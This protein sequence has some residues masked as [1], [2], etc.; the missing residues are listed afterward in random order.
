MYIHF[1]YPGYFWVSFAL[2]FLGILFNSIFLWIS[3][4]S[5]TRRKLTD[6]TISVACTA[7]TLKGFSLL[8]NFLVEQHEDTTSNKDVFNGTGKHKS[9]HVCSKTCVIQTLNL[10]QLK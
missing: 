4:K 10:N 1:H 9:I 7:S 6:F 8:V 3:T 5:P 2:L